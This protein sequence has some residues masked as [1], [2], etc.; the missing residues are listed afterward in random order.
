MK[1]LLSKR[2]F[3]LT[4]VLIAVALGALHVW[5]ENT[6]VIGARTLLKEGDAVGAS[7]TFLRGIQVLESRLTDIQFR[8][9]GSRTPHPDVVVVEVDERGADRY[10]LW[11]WSRSVVARGIEHLHAAGAAAIGLDM[12]FTD[13]VPD[14]GEEALSAALRELDR[15]TQDAP[16][17]QKVVAATWKQRIEA[18][19][20]LSPDEALAKALADA[21]EAVQGVILYNDNAL[22][23]L[24][25]DRVREHAALA[26][27][28]VIP[29]LAGKVPGSTIETIA[30]AD[31]PML[32]YYGVQTPLPRFVEAGARFAYFNVVPDADGSLRRM[33]PFAYVESA[34]G[35][36]TSLEVQTAA[37]YFK[38]Q[39]EIVYDAVTRSVLGVRLRRPEGPP[40]LVPLSLNEPYALVN[41]LGPRDVF[42]T[43]SF[44]DVVDGTFN[45]AAVK[46][47]AV[48]LGVTQAGNYDQ[49]VTPFSEFEP[50]VFTHASFLSNILEGRFLT[51]PWY[52]RPLELAFLLVSALF[53]GFW[54]PRIRFRWKLVTIAAV[55]GGWVVLDQ[56]AF[57]A[58][59]HLSTLIPVSNVLV[60]SFAVIF[61]G[62]LS[63]DTERQ[64][65]SAA[66]QYRVG[67]KVMQEMLAHPEKFKMGGERKELT[68]LFSD[69]RGFTSISERMS[70]EELSKFINEYL[71][72][73]TDIVF[74]TDGTLDK[75][76][77]D[78]VM[79]FWGAPVDQPD[80]ATRACTAA[81]LM[82]QRLEELK[83]QWRQM[84]RPDFDIGVGINTGAMSVG[85]M[86]S[87]VRGDYTV[88]GDAVNLA[89]RLEGTN[90]EYE[91]RV[92]ISE[93]TFAAIQGQ[94]FTTRRLGAVRVKGKRRPVRIYELRKFGLPEGADAEAVRTMDEGLDLYAERRFEEAEAKFRRVAELWPNDPPALRYLEEI[95]VFKVNPPGPGWDG[96]YT[97]TTK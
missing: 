51:R 17:E 44:A 39:P 87:R 15:V 63:A 69:I 92:L 81:L 97:A 46:G 4:A 2:R 31:V 68:V 42:R 1:K 26:R 65:L 55:L 7:Q 5:V 94:P 37:A 29:H 86:G 66:F 23:E 9:R 76:I 95:A 47:K 16:P 71:T 48:L 18:L 38:T 64:K 33:P 89:S 50:G 96:V 72:P 83:K 28:F 21:P 45:P 58:N 25:E 82:L 30:P 43:I 36:L 75:Y 22:A 49:R 56:L 53:L 19:R 60:T 84:G 14:R 6:P 74:Q 77:G 73:M 62:Y 41:H 90:K 40:V 57:N 11:P 10:G 91:T 70:A 35:M 80:H 54:L 93:G 52:G 20:G 79:A 61:L 13:V 32:H 88:M 8:I 78:A 27:S 24:G 85:F 12:T 67:P 34:Q 3:E 59:V